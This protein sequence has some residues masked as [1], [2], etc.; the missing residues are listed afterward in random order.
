MPRKARQIS[1]VPGSL[2]HIVCRGNNK[3]RIFRSKID[4]KAFLEILL[5]VKKQFPFY[6]YSFNPLPNHYHLEI[7]TID[8]SLSKI[9]HQINF[10]YSLHFRKRYHTSGHLFQDRFYSSLINKESYFWEASRYIDLN[11]VRA[12]LVK[13]PQDYRWSSFSI[14]YQNKLDSKLIDSRRFLDYG[15]NNLEESRLSYLQFVEEGLK[16]REKKPPFITSKKFV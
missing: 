7:E 4:Y 12:G 11:A 1:D 3:R 15:G 10:L 13:K 14:Y 8:V 2:Y 9:M 6:L 5:K 16:L